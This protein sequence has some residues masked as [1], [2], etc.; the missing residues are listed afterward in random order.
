MKFVFHQEFLFQTHRGPFTQKKLSPLSILLINGSLQN[1]PKLLIP[2]LFLLRY[3][4]KNN[5]WRKLPRQSPKLYL[6][7]MNL[8]NA[9]W[10]FLDLRGR[11]IGRQEN[12]LK[13]SIQHLFHLRNMNFI[14]II[15]HFFTKIL[16]LEGL[17]Y[18]TQTAL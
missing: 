13:I 12:R 2:K 3:G 5:L 10:N 9:T 1:Q 15:P 17:S 11:Q 6:H 18:F 8:L 16:S 7:S 4:R 14:S